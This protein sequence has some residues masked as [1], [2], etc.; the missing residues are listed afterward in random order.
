MRHTVLAVALIFPTL[1]SANDYP[2]YDQT[3]ERAAARIVA[4][5]MGDIRAG[6]EYDEK[7]EFVKGAI[8]QLRKEAAPVPVPIE[9]KPREVWHDGLAPAKAMPASRRS[10]L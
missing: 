8:E 3:I 5:K 9:Q 4:E 2:E 6:F 1:A 10:D 7:P